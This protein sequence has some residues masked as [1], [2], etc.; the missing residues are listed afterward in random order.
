M[1]LVVAISCTDGVVM[2]SDSASTDVGGGTK[3]FYEK[4][5]RLGDQP[6]LYGGAGDVG[7]LQQIEESLK[8]FAAKT[9]LKRIR[10]ELK[11]LVAP[12]LAASRQFHVPFPRQPFH[13]PPDA[14]LLFAGVTNKEPWIVEIEK[15]NRDTAYGDDMGNFAAIGSG[16]PL[17][18]AI[19]RPHL[20]T[21]RD[22]KLGKLFAYRVVDDA[23]SLAAMG[24]AKPIH[25]WTVDLQ[26]N[27]AKCD[28]SEMEGLS[29]TCQTWLT[30]EAEAVGQV[31]KPEGREPTTVEVPT[32]RL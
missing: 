15:D 3:Q 27:I 11:K 5:K 21:R 28:L 19:F 20:R 31:L 13:E 12:E 6:V 14:V 16:K 17:A 26:G 18:Q 24:L 8:Q 25:I 23:I 1:T 9:S 10:Q 32:P 7:L 30:L 2:A 29:S 4:V 22:L